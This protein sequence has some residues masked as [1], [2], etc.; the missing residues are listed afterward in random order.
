MERRLRCISLHRSQVRALQD[1][2]QLLV[3]VL[4]LLLLLKPLK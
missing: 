3:V 1:V 4:E 2:A